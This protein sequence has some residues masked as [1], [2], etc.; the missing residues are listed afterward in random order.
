MSDLE[1]IQHERLRVIG[2]QLRL[3]REARGLSLEEASGKTLIRATILKAIEE[4]NAAPLP[5]PVYIRG[6]IRRF[7]DVVGLQG[8]ELCETFP[9][10][11]AHSLHLPFVASGD[12]LVT[13]A[14]VAPVAVAKPERVE[15]GRAQSESLEPQRFEDQK[16]EPQKP[17]P[18]P[19]ELQNSEP[20]ELELGEEI[21]LGDSL[22]PLTPQSLDPE[23]VVVDR[24]VPGLEAAIAPEQVIAE[25][26]A[27]TNSPP[28]SSTPESSTP[29][30]SSPEPYFLDR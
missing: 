20:I 21:E 24:L 4:G 29:E 5:E 23:P 16:L 27:D 26:I 9:W 13:A 17:D 14:T 15:P 19:F 6:F 22:P 2:D 3:A 1:P 25:P 28:E 10:E 30:S 8:K 18:Q 11:P 7:G 12:S